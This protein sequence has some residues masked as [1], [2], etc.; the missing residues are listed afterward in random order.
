M[1]RLQ[2]GN[3]VIF[4]RCECLL[5]LPYR[6]PNPC[7]ILQKFVPNRRGGYPRRALSVPKRPKDTQ[8]RPKRPPQT[9]KKRLESLLGALLR[10]FGCA[11]GRFGEPNG[12]KMEPKFNQKLSKVVTGKVSQAHFV[13]HMSFLTFSKK[14][15]QIF[16]TSSVSQNSYPG[17]DSMKNAVFYKCCII[18]VHV[19]TPPERHLQKPSKIDPKLS[20]IEP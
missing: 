19:S 11:L 8:E 10:R 17:G 20:K 18:S 15:L 12:T 2:G 5:P 1:Q 7:Q 14:M 13:F 4:V 16:Q 6:P 9:A 3:Y